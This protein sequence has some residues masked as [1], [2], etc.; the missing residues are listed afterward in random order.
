MAGNRRIIVNHYGGAGELQVIE[1]ERP[2]P[3]H[4]EVLVRVL[5]VG[6]SLPD[7]M[8]REGDLPLLFVPVSKLVFLPWV[9]GT[10]GP[11]ADNPRHYAV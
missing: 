5:A 8:M 6:V 4:N 1:E 2:V 11:E 3:N 7:V 10:P 9:E